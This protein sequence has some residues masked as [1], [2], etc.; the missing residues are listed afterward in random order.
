[1]GFAVY[2]VSEKGSQEQGCQKVPRTP[3]FGEDDPLGVRPD[4][5]WGERIQDRYFRELITTKPNRKVIC[6]LLIRA[7]TL[8]PRRPATEK[9]NPEIPK[10][11]EIG[12]T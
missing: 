2:K 12:K 5:F 8:R 6:R 11:G 3:P 10:I 7:L 4:R 1:M 9:K